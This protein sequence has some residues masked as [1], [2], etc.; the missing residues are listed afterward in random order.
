MEL[1]TPNY[2]PFTVIQVA[3]DRKEAK[4]IKDTIFHCLENT[5]T[6]YQAKPQRAQPSVN[7]RSK[8]CRDYMIMATQGWIIREQERGGE[9]EGGIA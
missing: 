6:I 7:P 8:I 4:G 3:N 1:H 5:Q 9:E 2:K